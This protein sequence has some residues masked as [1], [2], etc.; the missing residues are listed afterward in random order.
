MFKKHLKE[1][2]GSAYTITLEGIPIKDYKINIDYDVKEFD[3]EITIDSG[4]IDYWKAEGYYNGVDSEGI[5]YDGVL[6]EEFGKDER[7]INGGKIYG[8]GDLRDILLYYDNIEIEDITEDM[9]IDI[10]RNEYIDLKYNYGGGY[11]HSYLPE[12]EFT[13]GNLNSYEEIIGEIDEIV[14]CNF[15]IIKAPN[16]A[17]TINWFFKN[18]NNF[19]EIY[20]EN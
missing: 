9:I 16:I 12:K 20:F 19:D 4:I 6:I 3:V 1:G 5:Y 14:N 10:I 18:V 13:L 7:K 15:A 8:G 11:S 17:K 2:A